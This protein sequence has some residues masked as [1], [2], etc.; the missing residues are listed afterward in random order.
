MEVAALVAERPVNSYSAVADR[1]ALTQFQALEHAM[2]RNHRSDPHRIELDRTGG[3]PLPDAQGLAADS[4]RA[5]GRHGRTVA[6]PPLGPP[7]PDWRTP[8]R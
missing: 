6:T 5:P 7:D 2:H 3:L 8:A 4:D 1:L